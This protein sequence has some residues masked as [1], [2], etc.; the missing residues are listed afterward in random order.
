MDPKVWG[1]GWWEV[2]G[3]MNWENGTDIYTLLQI[4]WRRK[5]QLTSVFLPGEFHG[6]RILAGYSPWGHKESDTNTFTLTSWEKRGQGRQEG[7]L[8]I[9]SS[10]QL[11]QVLGCRSCPCLS[12]PG[13][14]AMKEVL[15]DTDL[16]YCSGRRTD[17]KRVK[18]NTHTHTQLHFV[19]VLKYCGKSLHNSHK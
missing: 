10:E 12:G 1:L 15:W 4:K 5:W 11:Q 7:W 8:E 2:L 6:Q 3:G 13:L 19:R 17:F 14:G 18:T 9:G 16:S